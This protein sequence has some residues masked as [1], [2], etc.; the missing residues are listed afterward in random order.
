MNTYKT[1]KEKM[2][3]LAEQLVFE[4]FKGTQSTDKYDKQKD[5]MI[6][7]KTAE[8][9]CQNRH[10]YGYFTVNSAW[11][12]QVPKCKT[13]DRLFF[14]EY[15]N[16]PDAMLWECIDRNNTKEIITRDGRKMVA[17][18]ISK[19]KLITTF[20]GKGDDLREYTSSKIF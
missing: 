6:G 14:V 9:K 19:M 15:D 16:S 18:P 4:Y 13:V 12:N 8:V 11:K 7:N 1:N 17:W 5:G 10:P 3:F 2:G 20:E